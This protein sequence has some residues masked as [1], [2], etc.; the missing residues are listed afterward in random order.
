MNRQNTKTGASV[1]E[2]SFKETNHG[3]DKIGPRGLRKVA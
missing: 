2:A 3:H 1:F